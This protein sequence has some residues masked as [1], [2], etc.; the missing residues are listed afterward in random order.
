MNESA[1]GRGWG[2]EC[3]NSF[4]KGNAEFGLHSYKSP[5]IS[6]LL[7]SSNFLDPRRAL[8]IFVRKIPSPWG[9][10]GGGRQ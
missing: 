5:K 1:G 2:K 8:R 3:T 9:G 10:G 4:L 7:E 6:Y